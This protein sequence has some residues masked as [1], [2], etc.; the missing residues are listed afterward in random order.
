MQSETEKGP[1]LPTPSPH[2]HPT[3]QALAAICRARGEGAPECRVSNRSQHIAHYRL[4]LAR[5]SL[6]HRAPGL[7]CSQLGRGSP[8]SAPQ[9]SARLPV[10][11]EEGS[12]L[13]K[14]AVQGR[15]E[16]TSSQ[17]TLR[18]PSAPHTSSGSSA[19]PWGYPAAPPPSACPGEPGQ[20]HAGGGGTKGAPSSREQSVPFW[21]RLSPCLRLHCRATALPRWAGDP[22][23][24]SPRYPASRWP[25]AGGTSN[26]QSAGRK[27]PGWALLNMPRCGGLAARAH[28]APPEEPGRG[29]GE[30]QGQRGRSASLCEL[31]VPRNTRTSHQGSL[32]HQP[33]GR[34]SPEG[35]PAQAL[36]ASSP[37]LRGLMAC[38]RHIQHAGCSTARHRQG[39][40]AGATRPSL[41]SR[42]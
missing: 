42:V 41:Q 27:T 8:P 30:A 33:C 11:H 15:D 3:R 10:E 18:N 37:G 7:G 23:P 31:G 1:T 13:G 2:S 21:G 12:Q 35:V 16:G 20:A 22:P 36:P 19:Q 25:G 5:G 38:T 34:C 26:S 9:T 40:R 4:D 17:A 39:L 14:V 29:E 6:G 28:M 24:R 32:K